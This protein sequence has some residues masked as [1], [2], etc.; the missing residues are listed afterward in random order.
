MQVF[1]VEVAYLI[2]FYFI[3]LRVT[4]CVIDWTVFIVGKLS[5]WISLDSELP[6]VRTNSEKV[7]YKV[8]H[9][10]SVISLLL[11]DFYS[12][13]PPEIIITV[14]YKYV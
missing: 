5:P 12:M 1:I 11:H 10:M 4:F 7:K 6:H 9:S 8:Y 3:T 13:M 14:T 2:V